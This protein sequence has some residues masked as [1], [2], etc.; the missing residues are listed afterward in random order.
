MK[1]L[2]LLVAISS[3]AFG[4]I[5]CNKGDDDTTTAD[6]TSSST[7]ATTG[8]TPAPANPAKTNAAAPGTAQP[9][10]AASANDSR[11]KPGTMLK[12]NDGK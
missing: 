10:P 3:L 4:M 1:K 9:E 8:A 6:T 12:G 2:V 5:G 7:G 11:W